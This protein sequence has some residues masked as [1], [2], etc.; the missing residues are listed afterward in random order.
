VYG[1]N[2]KKCWGWA[3]TDCVEKYDSVFFCDS[4]G[5]VIDDSK[6][7]A[8]KRVLGFCC[9]TNPDSRKIYIDT[10]YRSSTKIEDYL[11][12]LKEYPDY[13]KNT[14]ERKCFCGRFL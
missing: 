13:L 10:L 1:V 9:K 8:C 6:C 3:G 2:I 5:L 11:D 4:H 7:A 12:I 14:L